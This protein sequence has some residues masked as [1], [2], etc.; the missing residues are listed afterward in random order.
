MRHQPRTSHTREPYTIYLYQLLDDMRRG[1]LRLP[2]FQ[3][4][5]VWEAEAR[6]ALLK[7]IHQGLPIGAMLLWDTTR[8]D[9]QSWERV[10]PHRFPDT[11]Q[12]P[13]KYVLDGTQRLTTLLAAL[14]DSEGLT[15]AQREEWWFGYDAEKDCFQPWSE[16]DA[17]T[18]LP[19]VALLNVRRLDAWRRAQAL[20][21]TEEQL[22][23]ADEV[24]R[25]F[26]EY[27]VAVIPIAT[28]DL[29][30]ASDVLY[31]VNSQGTHMSGLHML[32]AR[33]YSDKLDLLA[34]LER[35][36]ER[37]RAVGW[38]GHDDLADEDILRVAQLRLGL[39]ANEQDIDR[40]SIKLR[41]AITRAP[42]TLDDAALGLARAATLL[43]EACS[44]AHPSVL[45]YGTQ[46][47]LLG[48]VLVENAPVPWQVQKLADWFWLTTYWG[49]LFG[50]PKVRPVYQHLL[51]VCGGDRPDWPQ[52]R[53]A[54]YKPIPE[55]LRGFSARVKALG[56]GLAALRPLGV[57]GV[58]VEAARLLAQDRA[59]ALARLITEWPNGR[60][61]DVEAED[62]GEGLVG[63]GPSLSSPGNRFLAAPGGLDALRDL[64]L[65]RPDEAAPELLASHHVLP[66]AHAL[67]KLGDLE[68]FVRQR[69]RDLCQMEAERCEAA[70][71]RF[72]S[73]ISF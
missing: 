70:R 11:N 38:A 46:A 40:V 29:S 1:D 15:G 23:R 5:F 43:R 21:L 12:T 22:E 18:Y 73:D 55:I 53:Y 44:V 62:A 54:E 48:A 67:L 4:P 6:L 36:R 72:F 26:R 66:E 51:R 56:L 16:R 69:H 32:H 7:T 2:R 42:E 41:A 45:P 20:R 50:R 34:Q 35:A 30:A 13:R 17:E 33:L 3:R 52:T 63:G 37:L 65:R 28:E 47:V 19:S 25:A 9:V 60:A 57:D 8:S 49:T 39:D 61:D 10:G 24:S 64:L 14:V 71:K 68:G 31:Q 27:K 59:D 58:Q